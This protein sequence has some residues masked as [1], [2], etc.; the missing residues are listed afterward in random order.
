V[1]LDSV[2]PFSWSLFLKVSIWELNC[3]TVCEK[4]IT[5]KVKVSLWNW[6]HCTLGRKLVAPWLHPGSK[7]K[8]ERW[9]C[10]ES[11]AENQVRSLGTSH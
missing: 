4:A 8:Q 5:A 7:T 2:I 6:R 11:P 10:E 9:A 3:Y 1:G